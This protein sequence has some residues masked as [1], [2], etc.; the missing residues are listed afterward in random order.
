[1]RRPRI[2]L[3]AGTV[4]VVAC[5]IGCSSS[6]DRYVELSQ[7]S[8]ARQAEQ[9][10]Q[11]AQQSQR[12]AEATHELVQAD[13]RART[14][15]FDAQRSLEEALQVE[16]AK[17]DGERD[18]LEQDRQALAQAKVR[19]PIIA[20]AIISAALLVAAILPLILAIYL[21]RAFRSREPEQDLA[22]LLVL[23]LIS[24]QSMLL[25]APQA[26]SPC[27]ELAPPQPCFPPGESPE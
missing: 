24:E 22:E 14:E 4:L 11:M 27:P 16:R 2:L 6:D 13:A 21:I 7:Q 15:M 5:V 1:M 12:V 3:W 25:P 9:N 19:E 20:S 23:E 8:V 10:R 26:K 17:L 18:R